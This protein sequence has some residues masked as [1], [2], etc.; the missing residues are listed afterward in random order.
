LSVPLGSSF[1]AGGSEGFLLCS[2]FV[3]DFFIS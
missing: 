3:G 1:F 2:S